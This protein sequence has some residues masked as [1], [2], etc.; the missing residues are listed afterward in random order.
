MIGQVAQ[1]YADA[2]YDLARRESA[3]DQV[4]TD[5]EALAR[6]TS[7][8]Q[9]ASYLVNPRIDRA[10]RRAKLA[11]VTGA[12]HQLTRNF[13]DLVF[14]KGR[15]AV[16]LE[17]GEAFRQRRL[18]E[19][20]TVEGVVESARPLEG[21]EVDR[22]ATH[23]G[24]RLGKTVHLENRVRADLIGGF[25]VTVGSSMIDAT[26]QGRLEDLK[27]RLMTAPLGGDV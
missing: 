5:V 11:S 17:V 10:E 20:G 16:L 13:V 21:A 6:E 23:L 14:D 1:R 8:E 24:T 15:E 19:S 18:D 25:R 12:F 4:A 3:L 2:L 27:E 26:V 9:V 22:L 7:R